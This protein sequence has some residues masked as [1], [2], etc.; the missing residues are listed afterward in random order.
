ML[1]NLLWALAEKRIPHYRAA[2]AI[3][4]S[5][6]RF[7]RALRRLAT[8]TANERRKIAAFLGYPENWLFAEIRPPRR[9]KGAGAVDQPAGTV[10]PEG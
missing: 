5:E 10:V 4:V 6:S 9:R 7:S 2:V 3:G 1:G 8:F